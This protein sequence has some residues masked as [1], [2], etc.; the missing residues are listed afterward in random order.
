MFFFSRAPSP[1]FAYFMTVKTAVF[2][3]PFAWPVSL[4]KFEFTATS[5][6]LLSSAFHLLCARDARFL[7]FA[8][9]VL[10]TKFSIFHQYFSRVSILDPS[11]LHNLKD[12]LFQN[13][14]PNSEDSNN[15]FD[16]FVRCLCVSRVFW[17]IHKVCIFWDVQSFTKPDVL[18]VCM[19]FVKFLLYSSPSFSMRCLKS[20]I[21]HYSWSMS[22]QYFL[23]CLRYCG[24]VQQSLCL[25]HRCNLRFLR[26]LYLSRPRQKRYQSAPDIL[27][28]S[29]RSRRA[30]FNSCPYISFDGFYSVLEFIYVIHFSALPRKS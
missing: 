11:T 5:V 4:I 16:S 23:D 9:S 14:C 12:H 13:V 29:H 10:S 15:S 27:K 28:W 21:L 6:K 22:T 24:N 19:K 7:T 25:Q 20:L 17:N 1:S 18:P 3:T 26:Y 30:R 2:I 8:I